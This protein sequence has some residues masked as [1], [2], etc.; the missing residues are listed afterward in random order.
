MSLHS[1][2][3]NESSIQVEGD[4]HQEG[5]NK[6]V[7]MTMDRKQNRK[8]S[9]SCSSLICQSVGLLLVVGIVPASSYAQNDNRVVGPKTHASAI[10][11]TAKSESTVSGTIQQVTSQHG[12]KQLVIEGGKGAVT[13]DLGPY[14]SNA[15][16]SLKAGD[17]VE[18]SGWM[19][20]SSNGSNVFIARQITAGERQVVIRNS[21]GMPVHPVPATS[22]KSQRVGTGFTGG[23]R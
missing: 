1:L 19:R 16:K 14:A 7:V 15:A 12:S 22:N 21:A 5:L 9:F 20:T 11:T 18:I 6:K 4:Q 2:I 23:A 17:H 13:A 10:S 8:K 3:A